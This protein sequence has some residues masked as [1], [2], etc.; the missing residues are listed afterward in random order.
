VV[1]DADRLDA[2]GA[3]GIARCFA[4]GGSR[5]RA[6]WDG[7]STPSL[8]SLGH[9]WEKLLKLNETLIPMRPGIWPAG[10]RSFCM[11]S[12]SNFHGNGLNS[13][14]RSG[15]QETLTAIFRRSVKEAEAGMRKIG[16]LAVLLVLVQIPGYSQG[17]FD[18]LERR[19]EGSTGGD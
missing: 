6:L 8:T 5:E 18:G 13:C 10:G 19:T 14:L 17:W 16:R 12:C 9:F 15:F 3:I 11:N 4:F 7:E 1:S 2:I